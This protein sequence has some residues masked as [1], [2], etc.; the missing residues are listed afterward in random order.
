MSFDPAA[1]DRVRLHEVYLQGDPPSGYGRLREAVMGP[2][3]HLYLTTS[4]CDGRGN[5]PPDRDRVLRVVG[6]A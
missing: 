6:G 1:P 4:N 3:C 2:D 5:C